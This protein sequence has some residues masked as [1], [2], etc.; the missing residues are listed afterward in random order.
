M[1]AGDLGEIFLYSLGHGDSGG[2]RGKVLLLYLEGSVQI[3][4]EPVGS[5]V[6]EIRQCRDL[7]L[8]N[9]V[10]EIGP[11]T[12]QAMRFKR[13]IYKVLGTLQEVVRAVLYRKLEGML[14]D[15]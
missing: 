7:F 14:T 5:V 10:E 2:G 15:I 3:I 6:V 12:I 1:A 11:E 9:G 8:P 4:S 13:D